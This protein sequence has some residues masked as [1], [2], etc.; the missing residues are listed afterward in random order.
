MLPKE[1]ASFQFLLRVLEVFGLNLT[2]DITCTDL[3]FFFC[4]LPKKQMLG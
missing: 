4:G 2:P 1:W 3:E